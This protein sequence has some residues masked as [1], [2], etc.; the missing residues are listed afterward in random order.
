[1]LKVFIP[2]LTVCTTFAVGCGV[3]GKMIKM[4]TPLFAPVRR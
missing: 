4:A 2:V 3:F 1:M